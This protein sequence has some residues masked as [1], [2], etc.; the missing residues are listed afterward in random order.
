MDDGVSKYVRLVLVDPIVQSY[1]LLYLLSL[2]PSVSIGT[3][4]DCC[5]IVDDGG[6][7]VNSGSGKTES[8]T[9]GLSRTLLLL[10]AS[11]ES[12]ILSL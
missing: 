1:S 5:V 9:C 10:L 3:D 2:V 8:Y 6:G 4:V 7:S 11:T 12:V